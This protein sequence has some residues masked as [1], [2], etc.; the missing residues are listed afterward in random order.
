MAFGEGNGF[1]LSSSSVFLRS[2]RLIGFSA[3]PFHWN[4]IFNSMSVTLQSRATFF[5]YDAPTLLMQRSKIDSFSA[6][7]SILKIWLSNRSLATT[8]VWCFLKFICFATFLFLK[9][10]ETY[11]SIDCCCSLSPPTSSVATTTKSLLNRNDLMSVARSIC[12]DLKKIASF[13]LYFRFLKI[14]KLAAE[15]EM[16]KQSNRLRDRRRRFAPLYATGP[17][18]WHYFKID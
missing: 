11:P 15:S 8:L 1:T 6:P 14:D 16:K 12:R 17:V 13:F 10:S 7:N 9:K 4:A 2:K 18:V 5:V 3:K